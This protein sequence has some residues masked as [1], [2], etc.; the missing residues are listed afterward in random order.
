MLIG[1]PEQ[2]KAWVALKPNRE[3][4]SVAVRQLQAHS[5]NIRKQRLVL[6]DYMYELEA[7]E[8]EAT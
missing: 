1:S 6:R 7:R 8:R 4:V 5:D 2:M 3:E